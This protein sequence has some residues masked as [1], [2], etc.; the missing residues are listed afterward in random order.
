[1]LKTKVKASS[2]TN[3]TDARYFA[4]WEVEWLGFNLEAGSEDYI[5]PKNMNAIKE[6]VDGVKIVGEFNLPDLE[7]VQ[8][9]IEVLEIEQAQVGPFTDYN[10]LKSISDLLPVMQEIVVEKDTSLDSLRPI[11]DQNA[12]MVE[13]FILNFD[14]NGIDWAFIRQNLLKE[15]KELI[16]EHPILLSLNFDEK[17]IDSIL[18]ELQPLGIN[19]KGGEEEKVGYKSYD[20]LDEIFEKIEVLV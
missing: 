1:M 10:T 13:V 6:W 3:L 14:K 17:N 5:E 20:E 15:L 12:D 4:A 8:S 16:Q 9:A 19:V 18:E 2:I 7:T 11:F